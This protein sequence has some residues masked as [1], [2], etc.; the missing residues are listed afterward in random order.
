MALL[1]DDGNGYFSLLAG[2]SMLNDSALAEGSVL[3]KQQAIRAVSRPVH[4]AAHSPLRLAQ[5]Q[6]AHG[7]HATCPVL[8]GMQGNA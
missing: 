1:P 5:A 4:R 8:L 3:V 6:L 2:F 7:I